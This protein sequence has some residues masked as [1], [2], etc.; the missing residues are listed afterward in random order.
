MVDE[1]NLQRQ[2]IHGQSD[3]GRPKAESARNSISEINPLVNVML[4]EVR[5]DRTTPW[6]SSPGTT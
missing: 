2:I 1:S 4:H 5:L 6:R 3:V